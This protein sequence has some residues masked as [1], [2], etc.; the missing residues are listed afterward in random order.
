MIDKISPHLNDVASVL[1]VHPWRKKRKAPLFFEVTV[2]I[3]ISLIFILI[4]VL[5]IFGYH[6]ILGIDLGIPSFANYFS[7][8]AWLLISYQYFSNLVNKTVI[9]ILPDLVRIR[10]TFLPWPVRSPIPVSEI[11]QFKVIEHTHKFGRRILSR[12]YSIHAQLLNGDLVPILYNSMSKDEAG[13]YLNQIEHS[14][15]DLRSKLVS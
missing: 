8:F 11:K 10:I 1:I 6:A 15:S 12:K 13:H 14:M 2:F 5:P 3:I 7:L 9:E 4:L